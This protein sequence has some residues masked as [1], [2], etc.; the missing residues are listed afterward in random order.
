V[1]ATAETVRR[2]LLDAQAAQTSA[3]KAIGRATADIGETEARLVQ[4]STHT[5]TGYWGW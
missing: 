2:A 3:E 4:V 1:K 5:P